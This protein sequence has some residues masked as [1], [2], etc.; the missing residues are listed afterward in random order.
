[1]APMRSA[2]DSLIN[3]CSIQDPPLAMLCGRTLAVSSCGERMR[4]SGLLDCEVMG[5]VVSPATRAPLVSPPFFKT[6]EPMSVT[7]RLVSSRP[8]WRS[9]AATACSE[10]GG[11][12]LSHSLAHG[13]YC[14]SAL[15]HA[16]IFIATPTFAARLT[17]R[18]AHNARHQPRPMAVGCMPWLD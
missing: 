9:R 1:M 4:A 8:A 16:P 17:S 15:R 13:S 12:T 7:S 2:A 18:G 3:A 14:P 10:G 11:P 5:L 6:E